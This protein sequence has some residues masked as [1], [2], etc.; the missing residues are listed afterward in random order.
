MVMLSTLTLRRAAVGVALSAMAVS[1]CS[2]QETAA[3]RSADGVSIGASSDATTTPDVTDGPVTTDPTPEPTTDPTPVQTTDQ[4]VEETDGEVHVVPAA[5]R[6]LPERLSVEPAE[7]PEESIRIG[8]MKVGDEESALTVVGPAGETLAEL[9]FAGAAVIRKDLGRAVLVE[10]FNDDQPSEKV[11][12]DLE[13]GNRF[14]VGDR[15]VFD[16]LRDG[17]SVWLHVQGR[18][19]YSREDDAH[20][21]LSRGLLL[22]LE[23]FETIEFELDDYPYTKPLPFASADDTVIAYRRVPD[24]DAREWE[25]ID[26]TTDTTYT[27][28]DRWIRMLS[29]DGSYVV[30]T[31]NT[32]FEVTS[33]GVL[34]VRELEHLG[35]AAWLDDTT[36]FSTVPPKLDPSLDPSAVLA[37][38]VDNV[39]VPPE[40]IL[41]PNSSW[42]VDVAT[43][44]TED[45]SL[46]IGRWDSDEF[47]WS[48][49]W[50]D[51][52]EVLLVNAWTG[53][54]SA[55]PLDDG[56]NVGRLWAGHRYVWGAGLPQLVWKD[57][58]GEGSLEAVEAQQRLH[59]ERD[60][61]N[62]SWVADRLTGEIHTF[63]FETIEFPSTEWSFAHEQKAALL[64]AD[65]TVIRLRADGTQ[66]AL[67]DFR[68][69]EM[70]PDGRTILRSDDGW[71]LIAAESTEVLLQWA[72][73]GSAVCVG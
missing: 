31:D 3:A 45:S 5:V 4:A 34:P 66:D 9:S 35:H 56:G 70:C 22:N 50:G 40:Y 43:G 28:F 7:F 47:A 25:I 73:I 16:R 58:F 21:V 1:G 53:E 8:L 61:I 68:D 2:F 60:R 24:K 62:T 39:E 64:V 48:V 33:E 72:D 30:S 6:A 52:D 71:S 18:S 26:T 65:G 14:S 37:A 51:R 44:V 11:V 59:D 27:F 57:Y 49:G 67:V 23:T 54:E 63:D 38:A 42:F 29:P 69:G 15:R 13:T 10:I 46:R 20:V 41:S 17:Q 36:L 19:E 32:V 55:V 12:V